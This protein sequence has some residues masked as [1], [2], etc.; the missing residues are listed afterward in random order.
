MKSTE[1]Y[2]DYSGLD[3]EALSAPMSD[4]VW[5]FVTGAILLGLTEIVDAI[6][7]VALAPRW[8]GLATLRMSLALLV[9]SLAAWL[10][11]WLAVATARSTRARP[12]GG[13]GRSGPV[14]SG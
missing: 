14:L 10:V 1:N 8:Y 2:Y 7:A 11:M 12:R 9:P 3:L 5:W 6:A 13:H 4:A